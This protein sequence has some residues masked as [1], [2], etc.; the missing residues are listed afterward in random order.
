[1][2]IT[3]YLSITS[4]KCPAQVFKVDV[5]TGRKQLWKALVPPDVTGISAILITP[6]SNN[7][8]YECGRT[9]SDLY[10]AKDLK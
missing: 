3:H 6:D 9:L 2:I 8:V 5:A 1:V 7:Y 10:L 4:A